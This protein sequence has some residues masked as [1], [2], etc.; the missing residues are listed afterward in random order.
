MG[1]EAQERAAKLEQLRQDIRDDLASGEPNPLDIEEIKA[2]GRKR[3]EA[4][5]RSLKEGEESGRADYSLRG[6]IEELDQETALGSALSSVRRPLSH[7]AAGQIRVRRGLR[8]HPAHP[9]LGRAANIRR[10]SSTGPTTTS[11]G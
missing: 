8:R 3:L 6:L 5:R 10:S 4:L 7:R 1:D 11:V 9:A 2:R